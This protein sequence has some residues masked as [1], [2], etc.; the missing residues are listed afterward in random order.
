MS[1]LHSSS[2]T[3]GAMAE[4]QPNLP[5]LRELQ[6]E[7]LLRKREQQLLDATNEAT[8]LRKQISELQENKTCSDEMVSETAMAVL[9]PH[10]VNER[11][12][13][14]GFGIN[15]GPLHS[16]LVS[17]LR[18]RV[19]ML[20]EE[21]DEL[22]A[23]LRKA[24]TGRLDE[25]A[26]A[27]RNLVGRLESSLKESSEKVKYLSDEMEKTTELLTR[28]IPPR[29]DQP[30]TQPRRN[31]SPQDISTKGNHLP[32]TGPRTHKKPR[33]HL[34]PEP[35]RADE[36]NHQ[37][38]RGNSSD[39]RGTERN[40]S[41]QPPRN[42]GGMDIDSKRDRDRERERDRVRPERDR[43][44]PPP[45]Q[46]ERGRENERDRDQER[47]GEPDSYGARGGPNGGGS[48]G[49]GNRNPQPE[50]NGLQIRGYARRGDNAQSRN[51]PRPPGGGSERT[52]GRPHGPPSRADRG[53]AERMGL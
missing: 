13:A 35:L 1:S 14:T 21:N 44:P 37:T 50:A 15:S 51:S 23:V 48:G 22:Y 42:S 20:Q 18:Q 10:L 45:I 9:V 29:S 16:G 17:A 38:S 43:P 5:S 49:G 36:R 53:L 52:G 41:V 4:G 47:I 11:N 40:S 34:S 19:T 27:L 7:E 8:Y 2:A 46:R 32:P 6:L 26:K 28:K 3:A 31:V 24:E 12:T 33:T 30:P 39:G 25:E